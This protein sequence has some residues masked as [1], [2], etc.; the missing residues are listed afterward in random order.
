MTYF[1]TI[2]LII[3]TSFGATIGDPGQVTIEVAQAEVYR[4]ITSAGTINLG[5][6]VSTS[7]TADSPQEL[8]IVLA[9]QYGVE[10]DTALR[11]AK[12]ESRYDP[13]ARNSRSSAK[14]VYQFIDRTWSAYCTGDVMSPVDNI[15]C[16]MQ[17]YP[18][19]PNWWEC[20]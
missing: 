13:E 5:E 15:E 3:A 19:Y 9:E 2:L 14:G 6:S 17:L 20:R 8:I 11:I 16:F 10:V 18:K 7:N 1:L 4:D 12:C